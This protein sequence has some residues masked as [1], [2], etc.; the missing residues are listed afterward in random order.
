MQII[1][2]LVASDEENMAQFINL[3]KMASEKL[4]LRINTSKNESHSGGSGQMSSSF[5]NTERITHHHW[6]SGGLSSKFDGRI[7]L[8]KSAM[9]RLQNVTCNNKISRK[10]RTIKEESTPLKCG[11]GE[12]YWGYPG[13]RNNP[14]FQSSTKY[15]SQS[16]RVFYARDVFQGILVMWSGEGL[17]SQ[18]RHSPR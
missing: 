9:I 10:R 15:R 12:R 14:Q 16:G 4:G 3:V 2:T 8:N 7:A 6:C 13:Q 17:E 11:S 18:K 1:S 5:Y